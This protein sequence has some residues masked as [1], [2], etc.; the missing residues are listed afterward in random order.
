MIGHLPDGTRPRLQ[1]DEMFCSLYRSDV[2]V[3]HLLMFRH[4]FQYPGSLRIVFD[5]RQ[6]DLARPFALAFRL[7]FVLILAQQDSF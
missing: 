3:P 5:M 4:H 6:V 2:T 1:L 7:F